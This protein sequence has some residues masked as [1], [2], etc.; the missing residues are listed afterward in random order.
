MIGSGLWAICGL[1]CVNLLIVATGEIGKPSLP[2]QI[3][4]GTDRQFCR[5]GGREYP[6]QKPENNVGPILQ[7]R[8]AMDV[9]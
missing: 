2:P 6:A 4:I 3:D 7:R 5:S 8:T 9:S 1:K